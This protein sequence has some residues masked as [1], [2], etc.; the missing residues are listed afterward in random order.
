MTYSNSTTGAIRCRY[1]RRP[2]ASHSYMDKLTWVN[3]EPFHYQCT[4]PPSSDDTRTETYTLGG[5]DQFCLSQNI[6][7]LQP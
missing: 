6:S 2:I 3:G 7:K 4:F 1:C 5:P